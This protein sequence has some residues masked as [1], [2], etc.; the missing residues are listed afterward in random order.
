MQVPNEGQCRPRNS[1]I[2]YKVSSPLSST[3]SCHL[4]SVQSDLFIQII[5]GMGMAFLNVLQKN[6]WS[7]CSMSI[8]EFDLVNDPKFVEALHDSKEVSSM[9]NVDAWRCVFSCRE[10]VIL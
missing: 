1:Y 8:V 9:F 4:G 6:P 2:I 10:H 3:F 7:D 5:G